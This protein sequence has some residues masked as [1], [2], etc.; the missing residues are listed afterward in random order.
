MVISKLD[1]LLVAKVIGDIPQNI[2]FAIKGAVI[3]SFL[4]VN[5]ID[6]QSASS[7]IEKNGKEIAAEA[8]KF[9]VPVECYK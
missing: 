9:T 6:Y 8:Q 1:A 4:D 5:G 2:N 7:D 3:K